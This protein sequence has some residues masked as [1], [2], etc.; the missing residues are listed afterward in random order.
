MTHREGKRVTRTIKEKKWKRMVGWSSSMDSMVTL[1]FT[2]FLHKS[3]YCFRFIHQNK[4]Q[5]AGWQSVFREPTS[6]Y[7]ELTVD[8]V[9]FNG[10]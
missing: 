6:T 3:W 8:S 1:D 4:D 10:V 7:Q 2:I 9:A 5:E